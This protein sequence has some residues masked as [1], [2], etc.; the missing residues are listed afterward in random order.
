[1][2]VKLIRGNS[3]VV[4][5]AA[6]AVLLTSGTTALEAMLLKK[7]MVVAYR[8]GAISYSLLSRLVKAPHIAL[9][10]LIAGER[11]VPELLQ[12]EASVINLV[13]QTR[14]MLFDEPR[15]QSLI[16]RFAEL[17]RNIRMNASEI[18]AENLAAMIRERRHDL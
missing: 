4:M 9:P 18:A 10:N 16:S 5:A 7:P 14:V 8:M 17:H 11:L 12:G 13:A 6:D 2:A 15:R 1:L 3:H